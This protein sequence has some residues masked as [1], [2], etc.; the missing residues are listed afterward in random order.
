MMGVSPTRP[1]RLYRVPPVDVHAATC[2]FASTATAPMVPI[3]RRTLSAPSFFASSCSSCQRARW[4]AVISEA[5]A[6][7]E[8]PSSRANASAPGPHIRTC[9]L[10]SQT[11]RATRMGFLRVFTQATAPARSVV[12]SMQLAS[13][14]TSPSLV[15]AAPV[16]ALK[17]GSSS[18]TTA[19]AWAASN[20]EPPCIRARRPASAAR[21]VPSRYRAGSASGGVPAPPCTMTAGPPVWSS[22]RSNSTRDK[23]PAWD[24]GAPT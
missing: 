14:S 13:S 11:R 10:S 8:K 16:P 12:P 23:S 19:A 7:W 17:L 4:R 6:T 1:G 15:R 24:M 18:S 2:P 5:F 20:A 22:S 9:G 3:F 21:R